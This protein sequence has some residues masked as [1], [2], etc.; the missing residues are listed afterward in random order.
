MEHVRKLLEAVRA[1]LPAGALKDSVASK[2]L[3]VGDRHVLVLSEFSIGFGAGGGSGE[4][5][6]KSSPRGTGG[7][8][9]G[10]AK[11]SPVAVLVVEQG[12]VRLERIG[13]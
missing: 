13:N 5:Q 4:S 3:L 8:G 11:A 12:K 6:E 7:G 2:P 9:G 1:R 10:G